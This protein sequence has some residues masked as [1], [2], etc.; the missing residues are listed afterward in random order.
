MDFARQ[1]RD[2]AKHLIGIA[3]VVVMHVLVIYAL[4]TGL[5]R[6]MVEVIKKPLSATI[7]EQIKPP[8][9]PPPPPK[10]IVEV[11][12]VQAPVETYVPPPD[13]PVPAPVAPPVITAVTPTPPAQPHVIA[14]P[15]VAPPPAPPPPPKPAIRKDPKRQSGDDLVYPRAAIRA[16]VAKGRVVARLKIDEKGNVS[17][18][19]IVSSDPPRVFDRTVID[20]VKDWKY[21]AEGEKYEA[22]IEVLFVLKD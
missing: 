3:F 17:D 8:P 18:V 12:K 6:T 11:P 13:I 9:P 2:P 5:G 21:K 7:V 15:V 22:E 19:V 16:G 4:L 1:Q 20:G 10:K 14:P